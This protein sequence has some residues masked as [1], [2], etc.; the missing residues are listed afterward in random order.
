MLNYAFFSD[1][2][3]KTTSF[4]WRETFSAWFSKLLSSCPGEL[5]LEKLNYF[6]KILLLMLFLVLWAET[7]QTFG[8]KFLAE[9]LKQHSSCPNGSF[10]VKIFLSKMKLFMNI[11]RHWPKMC[12]LLAKNVRLG[13]Q[14][15]ILRVLENILRKMDCFIK[16]FLFIVTSVIFDRTFRILSKNFTAWFSKLQS[17]CPGGYF[18]KGF[19]CSYFRNFTQIS[20]AFG[21]RKLA[22]L[23]ELQLRP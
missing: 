5:S 13:S 18:D 20:Q 23:S 2:R 19:F 4:H 17:A 12:W 9:L 22:V 16:T 3:A 15:S 11:V 14:S 6:E 21:E 10:E 7:Y 8:K 1:F